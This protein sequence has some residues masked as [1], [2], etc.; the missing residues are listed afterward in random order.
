[1]NYQHSVRYRELGRVNVCVG[2][3][4]RDRVMIPSL[5][6]LLPYLLPHGANAYPEMLFLLQ[7]QSGP[8]HTAM[9]SRTEEFILSQYQH[10]ESPD[11]QLTILWS[12]RDL[13]P[14]AYL[15]SWAV[16]PICRVSFR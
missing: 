12:S 8:H 4:T 11:I 2:V 9:A 16:F 5:L 15:S 14:P 10:L 3:I 1:M 6:Y 13:H 7:T